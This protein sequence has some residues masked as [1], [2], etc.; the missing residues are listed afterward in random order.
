MVE[1]RV[2][3]KLIHLYIATLLQKFMQIRDNSSVHIFFIV[4]TLG[5][6]CLRHVRSFMNEICVKEMSK[7]YFWSRLNYIFVNIYSHVV[8]CAS[9]VYTLI[10][11]GIHYY[12]FVSN[13]ILHN[14]FLFKSKC[15]LVR[16]IYFWRSIIWLIVLVCVFCVL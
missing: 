6:L 5:V 9:K 11:T 16:C 7:F 4:C 8:S 10:I 1:L 14:T 3:H 2:V 13:C 12:Y 15:S